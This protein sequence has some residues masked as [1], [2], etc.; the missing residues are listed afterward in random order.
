MKGESSYYSGLDEGAALTEIE[1]LHE[2]Y[3]KCRAA[4][5]GKLTEPIK[6]TYVVAGYIHVLEPILRPA[7]VVF[8]QSSEHLNR[9]QVKLPLCDAVK[10]RICMYC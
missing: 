4:I 8:L 6:V 10:G 3:L 5:S 9:S 7:A 2:L 1:V